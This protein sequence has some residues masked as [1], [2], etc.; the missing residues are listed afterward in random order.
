MTMALLVSVFMHAQK[1]IYGTVTDGN[2]N[3]IPFVNILVLGTTTGTATD[4]SGEF[5]L[6]LP[7]G[8]KELEFSA[9]GY[10]IQRLTIGNRTV[11]NLT[12]NE[13]SEV[14]DEVVLT[15]LGLKRETKELGYVVQSIDAQGVAEVKSVNFLDNLTGKL[16]GVTINQGPT[17]VGSTSRISIRGEASFSNNNPL[18]VVD[19]IP[20]NNNSVFNFTNERMRR[21]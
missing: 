15:A 9:L 3:P 6:E 20:I 18:F 5:T 1:T 10:L 16:A 12:L 17:G 4:A 14:L 13:D 19:G 8:A 2:K 11:I 7:D 21:T